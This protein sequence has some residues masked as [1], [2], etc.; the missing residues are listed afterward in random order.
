MGSVQF[1]IQFGKSGLGT[2]PSFNSLIFMFHEIL[3][4]EI[5]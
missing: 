1:L 2:I 4:Y 3:M 5:R